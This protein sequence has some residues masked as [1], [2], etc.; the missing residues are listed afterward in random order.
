MNR[1]TLIPLIISVLILVLSGTAYFITFDAVSK[2]QESSF[3]LA[4]EINAAFDK[5][6]RINRAQR[7]LTLINSQE[8]TVYEYLVSEETVVDFL[9]ILEGVEEE[10]GVEIEIVSVAA[11]KETEM[12]D[13]NLTAEGSF[14]RVMQTLGAIEKLPV[15]ITIE[16]G[17][18]ETIVRDGGDATWTASASY[19]VKQ[20]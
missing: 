5:E 19:S 15:F 14:K 7:T 9:E 10:T 1:R 16:S 17:T 12:F 4:Q 6:E 18:I 20:Q 11:N 3:F 8:S 2:L 13:I